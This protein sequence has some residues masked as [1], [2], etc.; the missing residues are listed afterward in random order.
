MGFIFITTLEGINQFGYLSHFPYSSL[1]MASL[2][3]PMAPLI[4]AKDKL[5]VGYI[6]LEN[7]LCINDALPC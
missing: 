4:S 2:L 3:I 5:F 7:P 1:Q 6:L